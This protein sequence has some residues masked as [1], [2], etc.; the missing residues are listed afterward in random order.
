[1]KNKSAKTKISTGARGI[2]M[3]AKNTG[4]TVNANL[5]S[6]I[7]QHREYKGLTQTEFAKTLHT[8]QSAVARIEKGNQNVTTLELQKVSHA[9]GHR[10]V[11]ISDSMDVEIHGGKKLEGSVKTNTS[12]NGALGLLCAALLNRGETTLHGIPR[13]QE[14]HRILETFQSIGISVKW[15]GK[16]SLQIQPPKTYKMSA[17]DAESAGRIRSVLMI[18]GPLVHRMP[19]FNLPHAGGCKMGQR[20]IV[21]HRYGLEALGVKI[22]TKSD[23]YEISAK[24]LHPADVI[25]YE[26]SD[27]AAENILMCAALIPGKTT[28]QFAPPNYQVQEV[29]FFLEALG[30][31]IEGIGT[32]T[33]TVHGVADI[34][35]KIEYHN[36]EDPTES[37][38]FISAAVTTG[39]KLTIERCP[40]DFLALEILKLEKMGL[41][42]KQSKIYFSE[43]GRTKLLDITVFPSKLRA[44][45]DKLHAQ[46]YPGINTD[47]LPFFV[48]IATQAEGSTLVH[49][50]MWENR[51][52]YFTELCKLG[53][54]IAL[55]DPHRVYV[56]GKTKLR[57]TQI[58]CPP[59]LRPAMIIM[60]A[61]LAAE[62]KSILRNIYSICRGYEDITERLNKLGADIRV[63]Q[64]L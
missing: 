43:N 55:A 28:I 57:G 30:V 25:M 34:N 26:A 6:F 50:W 33:M 17:L 53:A 31:K 11:A 18:I 1:M 21:A 7:K 22:E 29:C 46:P 2:K 49:D 12:K 16:N 4:K 58:V 54:D 47:N 63:I 15:V 24:K 5:G 44:P 23:Y 41:K 52:I 10:V 40:I 48:P 64:D 45:T 32:T 51:A 56:H 38:M 13:I 3:T 42:Y 36:S 62:G 8:S 27:T 37:M 61:M 60:I 59:A 14:V 9:L 20:T 39:S 19:T 35:Q